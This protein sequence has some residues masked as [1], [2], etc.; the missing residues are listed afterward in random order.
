L[1][2]TCAN[3][4]ALLAR[5]DELHLA[6]AE[7]E[8]RVLAGQPVKAHHGLLERLRTKPL[9]ELR[10]LAS[11]AQEPHWSEPQHLRGGERRL[12]SEQQPDALD[13]RRI[14][15]VGRALARRGLT[16]PPMSSVGLGAGSVRKS[17]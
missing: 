16:C 7:G 5:G 1:P 13:H 4:H 8:L 2:I 14:R 15:F 17:L 9:H 3:L 12:G 10:C 11:A 6:L